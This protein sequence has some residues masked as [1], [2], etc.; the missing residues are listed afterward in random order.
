[1]PSIFEIGHIFFDEKAAILFLLANNVLE[2]NTCLRCG[3]LESIDFVR[4]RF[5]CHVCSTERSVFTRSFFAGNKLPAHKCLLLGYLWLTRA[6]HETIRAISGCSSATVTAY[7]SFLR[8]LIADSLD[9]QH[10][11]IG[12][13]GIRV[14]LDET[15]LGKRK[16]NRGHRVGFGILF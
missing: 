11:V 16:Y 6:S 1:M 12:G 14:E 3:G 8:E 13:P 7:F 5:R 2:R 9:E 15:K 10:F 4:K